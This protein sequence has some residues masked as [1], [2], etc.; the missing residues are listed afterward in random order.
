[1]N[2]YLRN[3][4]LKNIEAAHYEDPEHPGRVEERTKKLREHGNQPST[5]SAPFTS[6]EEQQIEEFMR[7]QEKEER[8][9]LRTS[10]KDVRKALTPEHVEEV[11]MPYEDVMRDRG[12][13]PSRPALSEVERE[14]RR[15]MEEEM[16]LYSTVG[17]IASPDGELQRHYVDPYSPNISPLHKYFGY[18]DK[19]TNEWHPT[20]YSYVLYYM[21]VYAPEFG[22]TDYWDRSR[23]MVPPKTHPYQSNYRYPGSVFPFS[24]E[25]EDRITKDFPAIVAALSKSL[26]KT[27]FR[28]EGG[29]SYL[30]PPEPAGDKRFA[31]SAQIRFLEDENA[32]TVKGPK[33]AVRI[34][35]TYVEE[36]SDI[37]R[38]TKTI[39]SKSELYP[40]LSTL[41]ESMRTEITDQIL[42]E[43]L[44]KNRELNFRRRTPEEKEAIRGA[45]IDA[46]NE[47][48]SGEVTKIVQESD[49]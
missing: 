42:R 24:K 14:R 30:V 36:E 49:Y 8:Q 2:K 33:N 32:F 48:L 20:Q 9:A 37:S 34:P 40:K 13:D 46:I 47:I 1:M 43:V 27:S 4:V 26:W 23:K 15:Q 21:S 28:S 18:Y 16:N 5:P 44:L 41:I 11:P 31:D 39:L 7:G 17:E 35:S 19:E 45:I 6:D 38:V 29:I 25:M 12:I 22:L 10:E 3:L